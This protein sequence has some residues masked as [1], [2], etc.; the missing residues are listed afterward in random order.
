[1]ADWVTVCGVVANLIVLIA[2]LSGSNDRGWMAVVC[3]T[4]SRELV[5]SRS[6]QSQKRGKED[7]WW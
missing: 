6:G 4:M 1:M 3:S 5:V 2:C 7:L